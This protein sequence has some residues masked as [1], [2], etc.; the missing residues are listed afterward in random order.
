MPQ[1][2][3][4]LSIKIQFGGLTHHYIHKMLKFERIL[5][6]YHISQILKHLLESFCDSI[7]I[8][9]WKVYCHSVS[10]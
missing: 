3:H 5:H 7:L 10:D 1:E 4:L 9:M 8:V 6:E 2:Y